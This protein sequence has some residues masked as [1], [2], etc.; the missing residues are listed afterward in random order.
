M[1]ILSDATA[2]KV[3]PLCKL[4]SLDPRCTL[5]YLIMVTMWNVAT[6]EIYFI[7]ISILI[8]LLFALFGRVQLGSLS[9]SN[10]YPTIDST[11]QCYKWFVIREKYVS[12]GWVDSFKSSSTL[13]LPKS[14]TSSLYLSH[15]HMFT[16]NSHIS[17]YYERTY[18]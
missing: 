15:W 8:S 12:T 13:C 18:L 11:S 2:L 6:S 16:S 9:T 7:L 1:R 10:Y 3:Q 5:Y 17:C 14:L 4:S